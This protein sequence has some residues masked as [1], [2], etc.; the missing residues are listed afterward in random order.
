ML[1]QQIQRPI[2]RTI[3]KDEIAI[4]Q[5]IIV[6]EEIRKHVHFVPTQA[7][8]VRDRM[9]PDGRST[10]S[11]NGRQP[12]LGP[13]HVAPDRLATARYVRGSLARLALRTA[14]HKWVGA[15]GRTRTST[16][17][18]PP[19]FESGASTNSATGAPTGAR[20]DARRPTAARII[21]NPVATASHWTGPAFNAG[22]FPERHGFRWQ[23]VAVE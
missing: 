8:E 14:E 21:A 5:R 1:P 3:I 18:N 19:D 10:R 13:L 12:A 2:S 16:D 15:P 23:I 20:R 22:F 11:S 9:S 17:V 6:P 7:I 4:D